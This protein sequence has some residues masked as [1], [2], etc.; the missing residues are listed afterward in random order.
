MPGKYCDNQKSD[1]YPTFWVHFWFLLKRSNP[2]LPCRRSWKPPWSLQQFRYLFP[3]SFLHRLARFPPICRISHLKNSNNKYENMVSS[4]INIWLLQSAT[5]FRVLFCEVETKYT[6]KK[7][8]I[9]VNT[10]ARLIKDDWN[11]NQYKWMSLT[12]SDVICRL[13]GEHTKPLL[14]F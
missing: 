11:D 5:F 9:V 1:T 10:C 2:V 14:D 7:R 13:G 8:F 12:W 3:S 6:V 4:E